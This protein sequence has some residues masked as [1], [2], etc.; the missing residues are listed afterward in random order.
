MHAW[1]FFGCKFKLL[2]LRHAV[3]RQPAGL[4]PAKILSHLPLHAHNITALKAPTTLDTLPS[5]QHPW[6]KSNRAHGST[7]YYV[8]LGV[9]SMLVTYTA[10][11]APVSSARNLAPSGDGVHMAAV[12]TP[13]RRQAEASPRM[14]YGR[15]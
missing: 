12:L 9:T 8:L 1:F 14:N 15:L 3:L 13:S 4:K 2:T 6:C 10:C 11:T 5:L 7:K